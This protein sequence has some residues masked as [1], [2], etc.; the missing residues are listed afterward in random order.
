MSDDLTDDEGVEF[1]AL[2]K[3][4]AGRRGLAQV[5][6][7]L[8]RQ[9]EDAHA[10]EMELLRYVHARDWDGVIAAATA[11]RSRGDR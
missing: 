5:N 3:S 7:T 6:E 1:A 2:S 8:A 9:N 10:M 4:R 11:L